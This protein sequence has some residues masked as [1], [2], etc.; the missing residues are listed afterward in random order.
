MRKIIKL[1]TPEN[2][3]IEYE[4]AGLGSRFTAFF[5][6]CLI[7]ILAIIF[8]RLLMH[9]MDFD[10]IYIVLELG[11]VDFVLFTYTLILFF[12]LAYFVFFET[13]QK[14]LTPGKRCMK[15]RVIKSWGA[16]IGIFDVILR[17]FLRLVF[18]LPGFFLVDIMFVVLS[19]KSQRIGDFAANTI[20]VKTDRQKKPVTL[21]ELIALNKEEESSS[22]VYPVDNYEYN[23]LKDFLERKLELSERREVIAHNLNMYFMKK[24]N[25]EKPHESPYDFFEEIINLNSK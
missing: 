7:Q 12:H 9:F 15:L 21:K 5:I 8:I 25:L 18:S 1:L 11:I 10:L 6:D 22:N 24:F 14:G 17:G 19:N 13:F 20:V 4:L 16:P 3:H 23:L 2:V